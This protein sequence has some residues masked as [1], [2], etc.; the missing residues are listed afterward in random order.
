MITDLGDDDPITLQEACD[1]V[2]RGKIRVSTLLAER[3]KGNLD[4]FK[5]GRRWFT[6][7]RNV[8]EMKERCQGKR[9]APGSISTESASN[10]LSEMDRVSSALVA[11]SQTT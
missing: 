6:T 11:L 2:Y 7:L 3:D 4:I 10:G 8:R 9:K 5:V 1:M